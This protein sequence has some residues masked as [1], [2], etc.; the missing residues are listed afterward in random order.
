V[1]GDTQHRHSNTAPHRAWHHALHT[2]VHAP[3]RTAAN[4][5]RDRYRNPFETLSFFGVQPNHTVVE[6]WPGGGWYT[7]ILAPYLR[8]GGG[9]YYAVGMSEQQLRRV[10]EWRTANPAVYGN[11]RTATFPAF[12]ANAN[13]VP[14]G[15]ADAVLTFRNVHNWVMGSGRD[16]QDYSAEAFPPDARHAEAGRHPRASRITAC[17]R[18]PTRRASAAAATSR[19]RRCGGWRK[20]RLRVRRR[21]RGQRQSAR[22]GRLAAGRVDAAAEPALGDQDRARYQAIG[23]SDRM[24]LLFRKRR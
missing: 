20:P 15:T 19:C 14:N 13:R 21:E 4:V 9:T 17:P 8:Q 18:A 22:H 11:I 1:H 16:N 23:E 12:D 10:N 24:T 7:E 5:Q 3:T 2:A 6:V